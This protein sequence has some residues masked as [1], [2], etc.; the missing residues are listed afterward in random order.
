MRASRVV[1]PR[2]PEP[3][4]GLFSNCLVAG[5]LVFLTGMTAAGPD[6]Q[7]I[8][9]DSM[10]AQTRA[11]LTKIRDCLESAGGSLAD[12]VRL[13]IYVT[14]MTRRAEV[15]K[16]RSEFFTSEPRPCSTM[17][18]VKGFVAAGLLVEIEAT[19]VLQRA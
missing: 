8:G 14:D 7:P 18:E 6:G 17:V 12:V 1:S 13:V 15:G 4:G 9:G 10:E 11:V 2:V 3:P 5:N 16:V 19:A